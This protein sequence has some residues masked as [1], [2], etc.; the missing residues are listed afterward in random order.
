M[1]TS[2]NTLQ[3]ALVEQTDPKT[4][5]AT[6]TMEIL[7]FTSESIV[8]EHTYADAE[9]LVGVSR[10][11]RDPVLTKVSVTGALNMN[12]YK[13]ITFERLITAL[14][15]TAIGYD[16]LALGIDPNS[17]YVSSKRRYF[18][19]EKR[20]VMDDGDYDYHRYLGCMPTTGQIT[21][22]PEAP[23]T[24]SFEILGQQLVIDN[25]PIAGAIYTPPTTAPPMSAPL[26]VGI[27]IFAEDGSAVYDVRTYCFTSLTINMDSNV[28]A[29]QCLGT[30]Y[31][32]EAVLGEFVAT[33]DFGVYFVGDFMFQSLK[34]R[35]FF[36]MIVKLQ[37][38][39]G[40]E[41]TMVFPRVQLTSSKLV[42]TG[43]NDVAI[44]TGQFKVLQPLA[45]NDPFPMGMHK[46]NVAT[47]ETTLYAVV[48]GAG[49]NKTSA[50]ARIGGGPAIGGEKVTIGIRISEGEYLYFS[51]TAVAAETANAIATKLKTKIDADVRFTAVV[52]AGSITITRV[53]AGKF[54]T[55][56]KGAI[57]QNF[58]ISP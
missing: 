41:Y 11:S 24:C 9:E 57:G 7:R 4:I 1:A 22:T 32:K 3:I 17:W 20:W 58:D 13:Q 31:D 51:D 27:E 15:G 37:D 46:T 54:I 12:V 45:G 56:I 38:P 8:E 23:I 42:G 52:T 50:T 25:T 6:P 5:P 49:P 21:I 28:T 39:E 10:G 2:V 55:H 26:V 47:P 53:D 36:R 34:T 40:N 44:I 35:E 19:I 29:A 14:M 43:K 16:P 48:S 30:Y 33:I 18:M